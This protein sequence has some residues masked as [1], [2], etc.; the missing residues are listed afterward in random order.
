MVAQMPTTCPWHAGLYSRKTTNVHNAG[1]GHGFMRAPTEMVELRDRAATALIHFHAHIFVDPADVAGTTP[2][3]KEFYAL[4]TDTFKDHKCAWSPLFCIQAGWL[5]AR[6]RS[7]LSTEL[8][9]MHDNHTH[10]A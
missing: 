8:Q 7:C 4:I 9:H 3:W 5:Q 2:A 1:W 6:D 10:V